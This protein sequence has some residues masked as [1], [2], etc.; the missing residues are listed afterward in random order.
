MKKFFRN[1][2]LT[3][4]AAFAGGFVV[5]VVRIAVACYKAGLFTC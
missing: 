4:I 2:D 1:I 3:C 5:V